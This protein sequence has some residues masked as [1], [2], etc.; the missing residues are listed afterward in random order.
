MITSAYRIQVVTLTSLSRPSFE[1]ED[2][3][4]LN[5]LCPVR[6]LHMYVDFV[7]YVECCTEL[8]MC[9]GVQAPARALSKQW[10][11]HLIVEAISLAYVREGSTRRIAC[12][13]HVRHPGHY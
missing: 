10:L 8:F 9:F 2:V 5:T 6:V 13:F 1:S 4:G 7:D 11:D 12:H 3:Q